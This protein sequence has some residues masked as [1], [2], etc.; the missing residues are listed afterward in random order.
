MKIKAIAILFS[1]L[2]VC[3]G[4]AAAAS[5]QGAPTC[6]LT[7]DAGSRDKYSMVLS[8]GDESVVS[9]IFSKGQIEVFRNLLVEAQKFALSDEEVGRQEP[10]TT[11]IASQSE[12]ALIIDVSKLDD[13]SM[14]FITLNTEAGQLTIEAGSALRRARQEQGV[15]YTLLARMQALLANAAAK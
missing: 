6:R 3:V 1:T 4:P 7:R 11:R 9:G 2:L 8:D 10:K 14:I 15:F 12:P 5:P 13:R